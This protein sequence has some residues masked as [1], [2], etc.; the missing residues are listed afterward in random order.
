MKRVVL[1]IFILMII[2]SWGF[3]IESGEKNHDKYNLLLE[4]AQNY[5]EKEIYI[6]ALNCYKEA[7][8]LSPNDYN[9]KLN[10]LNVY[11]SA[12]MYNS[13]EQ[14]CQQ[15]MNENST[16]E[17]IV[18]LGDYYV[19]CN[20]HDRAI[21]WYK[22]NLNNAVDKDVIHNKLQSLRGKYDLGYDYYTYISDF[23]NGCAVFKKGEKYGILNINGCVVL[24]AKFEFI[25]IFDNDKKLRLA[26]VKLEGEY[27]YVDK[28]GFKRLAPDNTY[29]YLGT[30]SKE[31][32]AL[33]KAKG[34]YGFVDRKFN[35]MHEFYDYATSFNDG[36]AVV[37]MDDKYKIINTKF[38]D[39]TDNT[40]DG[41]KVSNINYASRC[42]LL[43]LNKNGKYLLVDCY[44]KE[45]T[46]PI[47]DDVDFFVNSLE[48]AAVKINGLWGFID[49]NGKTVINPTYQNA[50]SFSCGLAPVQIDKLWGYIDKNESVIIEPQF[51]GAKSFNKNGV[52]AVLKSSWRTITL[53][54]FEK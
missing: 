3:V 25:N 43:F 12:S 51:N 2:F 7:L 53:K 45:I 37:K 8:K 42:E 33:V 10:I 32:Y 39:V 11:K 18:M 54:Y 47:Y 48:Y 5:M 13:F 9:I 21:E 1:I 34:K 35:E 28:N 14:Y 30:F 40:Y 16:D 29:E 20:K 41:V 17:L 23:K 6:E 26:P 24:K 15:L 31:G 4:N 22:E 27:Y 50:H 36:V 44:G 19:D 52:G 49:K 38:E 46:E